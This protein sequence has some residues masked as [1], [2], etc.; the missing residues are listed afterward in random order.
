[1][2]VLALI[3]DLGY[4]SRKSA[5]QTVSPAGSSGGGQPSS[6]AD[7]VGNVKT[8]EA[9]L[10]GKLR[11]RLLSFLVAKLRGLAL[12][13]EIAFG[14]DPTCFREAGRVIPLGKWFHE[15]PFEGPGFPKGCWWDP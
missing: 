11:E 9:R 15:E 13:R 7:F 3:G 12:L 14:K 8:K 2:C 10:I 5:K 6:P 1:M 4:P